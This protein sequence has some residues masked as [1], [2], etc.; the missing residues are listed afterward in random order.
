MTGNRKLR[1]TDAI[2]DYTQNPDFECNQ[3]VTTTTFLRHSQLAR[4]SL[5]CPFHRRILRQHR[6]NYPCTTASSRNLGGR[7][8]GVVYKSQNGNLLSILRRAMVRF[9]RWCSATIGNV[10]LAQCATIIIC[11]PLVWIVANGMPQ[12]MVDNKLKQSFSCHT[13]DLQ[14]FGTTSCRWGKEA[15]LHDRRALLEDGESRTVRRSTDGAY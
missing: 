14:E 4:L 1:S 11:L 9:P 10:A 7:G 6:P 2:S 13:K 5:I 8:I 12:L 15:T 3:D